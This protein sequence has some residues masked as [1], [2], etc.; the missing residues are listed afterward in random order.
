MTNH[1]HPPTTSAAS[2]RQLIGAL[3]C[4]VEG[5][6]RK[7]M[8]LGPNS[9]EDRGITDGRLLLRERAFCFGAKGDIR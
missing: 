3:A 2:R 7:R 9:P 5:G 4:G 8:S 6:R 1:S